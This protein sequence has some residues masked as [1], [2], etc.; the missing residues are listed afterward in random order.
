MGGRGTLYGAV[1][2]AFGG[3]LRQDLVHRRLAGDLAVRARRPVR[4][5]HAVA[6]QGIVG[7]LRR[8]EAT[9]HECDGTFARRC[10]RDR[11]FDFMVPKHGRR[12][13]PVSHGTMLYLEDVSVSFDGF[14]AINDLNLYVDAG[15]LRCI[16]GPNGAGKTTMMDI[17]TGKTRPDNGSCLFGQTHQP[18]A[19]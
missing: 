8:K 19:A 15:E 18:A 16:I 10:R 12:A 9:R 5:G 6:A 14:K 13:G 1:L 4:F 7:L 3:Q 17:I 2:G 11:V